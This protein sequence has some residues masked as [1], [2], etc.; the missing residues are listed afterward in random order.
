MN[1][2][3][4]IKFS[5]KNISLEK[6]KKC[7]T[8]LSKNGFI[9]LKNCIPKKLILKVKHDMEI[10]IKKGKISNKLRDIHFFKNGEISSAHNL[11]N[12][13]KSYKK[14]LKT[15]I[16]TKVIKNHLK[17]ISKNEFNSS[18]F[19]KPKLQGFETKP[20]QDNAFFCMEPA[21]VITCWMPIT[22]ANKTNGCLYYYAGSH[23]LGNLKH[24]PHGNLG[25]SMC[26]DSQILKKIK[27]NFRKI[28]IELELGDC[29]LHNSLVVH[30]SKS[31]LSNADRNAFNF[32]I[33]S[34][35]A[36]KNIPLFNSYKKN[37]DFFLTQKKL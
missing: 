3:F 19:A 24:K 37:L 16:V 4:C 21:D 9:V 32:S 1:N 13:V 8:L 7:T 23:N 20:H 12:Y 2:S 33:G 10:I 34:E 5:N 27:K 15:K 22:F 35:F 26:L 11:L 18:Y 31:N 36:S 6:L 17:K 29:V 25:A 14:L 30:G 28:Y